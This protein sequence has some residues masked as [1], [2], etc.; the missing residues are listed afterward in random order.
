MATIINAMNESHEKQ[1]KLLAEFIG[2]DS[3]EYLIC[4]NCEHFI[5]VKGGAA[6]RL[7]VSGMVRGG[8]LTVHAEQPRQLGRLSGVG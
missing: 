8:V 5:L 6:L 7:M 3:I 2:A 4:D 1:M